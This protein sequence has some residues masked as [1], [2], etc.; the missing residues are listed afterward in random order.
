MVDECRSYNMEIMV[1]VW[2]YTCPHSNTYNDT[3]ARGF[4]A[5]RA[6]GTLPGHPIPPG[7]GGVP[8]EVYSQ[9]TLI[10]CL[11]V[12]IGC[13]EGVPS[14]VYAQG[15]ERRAYPVCCVLHVLYAV[16]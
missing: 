3:L 12:V 5:T 15:E 11:D 7:G 6:N 1:S 2:P 14:E 16:C 4:V 10:G 8:A 9:G 13:L